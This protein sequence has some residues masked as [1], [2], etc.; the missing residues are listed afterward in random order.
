MDESSVAA[1]L[2]DYFGCERTLFLEV[3]EGEATG[4][5]DLY[6]AFADEG[7]ALV[8]SYDPTYDAVN[9]ALLDR[10]GDR[11]ADAGYAVVRVP[12]PSHADGDGDGAPEFRTYLNG[13]HLPIPGAPTYVVPVYADDT[14]REAEALAALALAM[15]TTRLVPVDATALIRR[16]GALHCVLRTIPELGWPRPC[17]G[18]VPSD[19][20][21]CTPE[22]SSGPAG[23]GHLDDRSAVTPLGALALIM[24]ATRRRRRRP[25]KALPLALRPALR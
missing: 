25:D 8:G 12:M 2:S 6:F 10:N 20:G 13:A 22:L 1:L 7:T 9:S 24:D 11:L 21:W 14:G 18:G 5:V 16:G 19:P 4:H 15:P 17:A 3:L 23:C